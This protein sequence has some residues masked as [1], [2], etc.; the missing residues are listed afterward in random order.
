MIGDLEVEKRQQNVGSRQRLKTLTAK[1]SAISNF[2]ALDIEKQYIQ[3]YGTY[4]QLASNH[5][6]IF[7]AR[8]KASE[9]IRYNAYPKIE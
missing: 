7:E 3:R 6:S 2:N 5:S 1:N 9:T 8:A 4:R